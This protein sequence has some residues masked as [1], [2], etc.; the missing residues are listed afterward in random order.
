M[1]HRGVR[2]LW[3]ASI[4]LSQRSDCGSLASTWWSKDTLELYFCQ[5]S[6]AQDGCLFW[7][8]C[9][10]NLDELRDHSIGDGRDVML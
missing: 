4:D 7:V 10:A 9:L 2:Q 3:A 1:A 5:T 6:I 8:W